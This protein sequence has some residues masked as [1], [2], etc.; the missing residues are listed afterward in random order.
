M[1]TYRKAK[2]A[3]QGLEEVVLDSY[4]DIELK[5]QR[6]GG[7]ATQTF[8]RVSEQL[9]QEYK[10]Q[11]ATVAE[12]LWNGFTEVIGEQQPTVE[13]LLYVL[14]MMRYDALYKQ[15][16]TQFHAPAQQA[17]LSNKAPVSLGA[18]GVS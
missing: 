12:A 16:E 2:E 18:L 3:A 13:T 9:E 1:T 11:R 14:E 8:E 6:T 5:P 10:Q 15:H 7:L 17:E 4:D